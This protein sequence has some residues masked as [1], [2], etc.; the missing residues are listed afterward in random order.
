MFVGSWALD[1]FVLDRDIVVCVVSDKSQMPCAPS[2][3][4]TNIF[5][6]YKNMYPPSD[7]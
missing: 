4:R 7:Y 6:I 2:D 3:D 1:S 5:T